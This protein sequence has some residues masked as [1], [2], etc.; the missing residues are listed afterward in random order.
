MNE[1]QENLLK[2]V[3]SMPAFPTSVSKVIELSGDINCNHKDL[4]KVIEHDPVMTLKVLKLVNSAYF[5]LSNKI[6]SINHAV[7][8]VGLNT[9]KNLAISIATIGMLP[10][11]NGAGLNMNKFLYHSIGTAALSRFLAKQVGISDK[12]SSD[13][14]VTGLLH[15]FGKIVFAQFIP[16]YYKEVLRVGHDDS[17]LIINAE[18]KIIGV[19]HTQVGRLLGQR[20]NLAPGVLEGIGLHHTNIIEVDQ[21]DSDEKE[22]KTPLA[23][24]IY[25]ANRLSSELEQKDDIKKFSEELISEI[26]LRFDDKLTKCLETPA[27]LTEEVSKSLQYMRI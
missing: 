12:A 24:V 18:K 25:V 23:D 7:V 15:D 8:Y 27:D 6:T 10:P 16:E 22:E 26:K 11:E 2:M 14:F 20:W 19:D 3:E 9:V 5:G 4:V 13:Y 17:Q 21:K 1:L